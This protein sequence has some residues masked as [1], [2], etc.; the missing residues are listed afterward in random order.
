M[1]KVTMKLGLVE[2]ASEDQ[3]LEAIKNITDKAYAAETKSIQLEADSARK[4]KEVTDK[5]NAEITA[6]KNDLKTANEA[7]EKAENDVVNIKA[8]LAKAQADLKA[9]T[10]KLAGLE[11]EKTAAEELQKET[12]AKALVDSHVKTGRIKNEAKIIERYVNMAK[13]DYEGA[14]ELIESIPLSV[15]APVF[16]T[17]VV[18]NGKKVEDGMSTTATA[19][20][21]RNKLK[22]EG[23]LN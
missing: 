15:K 22:R 7:R 8:T 5:A 20:A 19:L 18:N 2:A 23:R 10:D 17:E 3:I 6:A 16:Q 14:K 12:A 9:A 13:E 1:T 21:V 11:A 4:L